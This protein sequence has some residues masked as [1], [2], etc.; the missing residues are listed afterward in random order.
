M[1]LVVGFCITLVE[2]EKCNIATGYLIIPSD[3][4]WHNEHARANFSQK[5]A[6]S[7]L[8]AAALELKYKLSPT[9]WTKYDPHITRTCSNKKI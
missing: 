5:A 1:H 7:L 3:S 2:D 4:L 6:I 9:N 8:Q